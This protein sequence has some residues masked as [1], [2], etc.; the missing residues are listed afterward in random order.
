MISPTE[1]EGKKIVLP[2][3]P[4]QGQEDRTVP[5]SFPSSPSALQKLVKMMV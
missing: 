5:R 3:F 2:D 4:S 1:R